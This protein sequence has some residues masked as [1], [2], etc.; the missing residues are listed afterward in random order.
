MLVYGIGLFVLGA[1]A[2]Y[3]M[4]QVVILWQL[5]KGKGDK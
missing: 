4:G 2:G 3:I 1:I 5:L